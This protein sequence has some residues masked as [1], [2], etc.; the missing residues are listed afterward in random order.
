MSKL[1]VVTQNLQY[2]FIVKYSFVDS[3]TSDNHRNKDTSFEKITQITYPIPIHL[4]NGQIMVPM[5]SRTLLHLLS[6]L[7]SSKQCQIS[8][9]Q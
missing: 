2:A 7:H 5:H 3:A 1:N 8:N 9:D 4:T 6:I